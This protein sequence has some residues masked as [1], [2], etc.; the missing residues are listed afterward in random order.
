MIIHCTIKKIEHIQKDFIWD[1][2]KT[3]IKHTALIADYEE[4]GLKNFD[5][6]SKFEALR[7]T[8]VKRLFD[9]NHHPWKNIPLKLLD[10]SFTYV[11]IVMHKVNAAVITHTCSDIIMMYCECLRKK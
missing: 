3:H 10:D 6:V 7:L 11:I 8:W 2:K 4:G 9:G 5:I 1:R